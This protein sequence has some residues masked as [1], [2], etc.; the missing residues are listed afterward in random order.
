MQRF[1][2]SCSRVRRA[3][4][5]WELNRFWSQDPCQTGILV[6]GQVLIF[7]DIWLATIWGGLTSDPK[8]AVGKG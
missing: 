3:W 5:L 7:I 2:G 6:K 4:E 8:S 1:E